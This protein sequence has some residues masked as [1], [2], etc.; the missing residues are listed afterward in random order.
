MPEVP[1]QFPLIGC[2]PKVKSLD[3][4]DFLGSC[5]TQV[6][7]RLWDSTVTVKPDSVM[8]MTMLH[9]YKVNTLIP[10]FM[11]RLSSVAE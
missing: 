2:K 9:K 10:V 5:I 1:P 3:L 7:L 8:H 6:T 11:L 4:S